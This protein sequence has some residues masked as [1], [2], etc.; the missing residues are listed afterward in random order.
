MV[1]LSY[2]ILFKTAAVAFSL[3]RVGRVTGRS[4]AMYIYIASHSIY[5]KCNLI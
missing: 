4:R 3:A 2:P 5:G 1:A